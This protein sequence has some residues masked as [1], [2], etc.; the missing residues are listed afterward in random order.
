MRKSGIIED[1]SGTAATPPM[2]GDACR[3]E[4][5]WVPAALETHFAETVL[6]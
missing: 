4:K 3:G 2:A 1:N 6:Q 5:I